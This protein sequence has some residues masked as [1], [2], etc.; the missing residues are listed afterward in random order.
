SQDHNDR[1]LVISFRYATNPASSRFYLRCVFAAAGRDCGGLSGLP[2][3]R[4]SAS[5]SGWKMGCLHRNADRPESETA[6]DADL[7]GRA[8]WQPSAGAFHQRADIVD[9]ATLVAGWEVCCIFIGARSGTSA[10]LA[11]VAQWRRGS[12]SDRSRKRSL[13]L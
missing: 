7:G 13:E 8:R 4:R 10:D 1:A 11:A 6:Q 5:G 2:T 3:G 9:F 12:K